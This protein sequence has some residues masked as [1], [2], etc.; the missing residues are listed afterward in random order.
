MTFKI[1]ID[2][3]D[4]VVSYFYEYATEVMSPFRLDIIYYTVS[5]TF[6]LLSFDQRLL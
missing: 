1:K 2:Q 6:M 4:A 5:F 3:L